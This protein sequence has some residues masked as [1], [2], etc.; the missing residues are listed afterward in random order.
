MNIDDIIEQ[1]V[2]RYVSDS[3]S[4]HAAD[5]AQFT[6]KFEIENDQNADEKIESDRNERVEER[7]GECDE[8]CDV[9]MLGHRYWKTFTLW[10]KLMTFL[11]IRLAKL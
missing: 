2:E 3:G 8:N 7:V 4:A 10:M 11:T 6:D 5:K 1:N 9:V